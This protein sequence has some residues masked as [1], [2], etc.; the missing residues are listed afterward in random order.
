MRAWAVKVRVCPYT[1][2]ELIPDLLPDLIV[3]SALLEA[4]RQRLDCTTRG[5]GQG[6]V[7]G[8]I[9]AGWRR[10]RRI[11]SHGFRRHV[12]VE[13]SCLFAMCVIGRL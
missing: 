2:F 5:R 7:G 10:R 1:C 6:Q 9:F 4:M 12:A 3:R 11:E 8:L 13:V